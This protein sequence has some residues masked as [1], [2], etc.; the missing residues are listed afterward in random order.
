MYIEWLF[1]FIPIWVVSAAY[2]IYFDY[3]TGEFFIQNVI[4]AIIMGPI[5]ALLF[6]DYKRKTKK[7]TQELQEN[8]R[9]SNDRHRRWFQT[10]GLINRQSIPNYGRTIPPPPPITRIERA[11]R[12]RDEAIRM[13]IERTNK[14]KLKDF[15]FLRG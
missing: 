1:F 14:N 11:R 6:I 15:K 5:A 13:A 3:K 4:L 7:H 12:E 10:L 2:V 9:E 8:E